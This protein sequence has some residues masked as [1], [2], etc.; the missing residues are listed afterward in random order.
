M[1]YMSRRNV[2]A[3]GS[4]NGAIAA[5]RLSPTHAAGPPQ[6]ALPIPPEVR[7]MHKAKS[8]SDPLRTSAARP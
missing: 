1:T 3:A 2:L 7:Q 4:V 8:A 6:P 5:L